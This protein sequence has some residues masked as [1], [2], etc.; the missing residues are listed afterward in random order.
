MNNKKRITRIVLGGA[1]FLIALF[2][3]SEFQLALYLISYIIVGGDVVLKAIKNIFRGQVFDENFLMC[4]ATV[5]AFLIGEYPEGVAVML[6]YQVGEVFQS[7]AVDQSRKSI[8]S[9]MDIRPDY[10]NVKRGSEL[11]KMDPDEVK[12]DD[13]IV[14]KAG[15]R[16]P[17]D[18]VVIDGNSMIDTSALTGE[19]VPRE[20]S[21]G[22]DVLSGCININGVLTVRVTKEY[23][24][25]TV[26]K[27]LDLV[28]NAS[29]KKSNSENFITKFARY[30]TPAVVIVAAMLAV[31]P[32]LLIEG[33][34]FNEWIYRALTFLVISCPCALVISVPLSFFGGI[35]AASKSGVL[36]KGSNYLEA[37]A[38][39]EMVVF[40]KTGTLT[41]GVFTVQEINAKGISKDELLELTAYAENY[42][43]HPISISLKQAYNKKIDESEITDV[44]EISG[45]GV[46]AVVK[47]KTVYAGNI[48]LMQR[49]DAPYYKGE[50]V[51]TVV[52]VAIDNKYA[53]Y[54][55][56]ADEVKPDAA[57]AIHELKAANI[58]QTVML[59]GDSNSVG[60]KVAKE[61]GL[62]KAYTELLPAG[63]VEK[64][65]ELLR[66][67]SAKGK[68]AFVG[69]GINDA[70]VLARADI[71]IAMGGLGSD[72]AIEAADIVIMTDE[73]SKI[74]TAMKISKR[75]LGIAKQ[76]IVFALGVK[77]IVLIMGAA[78]IA[79]MWEAVFADV[80][81]SVIAILNAMRV[82][83]I[84]KL[85]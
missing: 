34:T 9:L 56:I 59:T 24:E 18:G 60:M 51:G 52:H 40:D 57:K 84:K 3:K 75:T 47:G 62:D 49:I 7:Y 10:A 32:P 54:I 42:S 31:L 67:K 25:S 80:G 4:I 37:L 63:K 28:E 76:N 15:E 5:G 43:N 2:A 41:K 70:P 35:G 82:L 81:V 12:I 58:K 74:A 79:T 44:E 13:I 20:L 14:I 33:A 66:Q 50:I 19:S 21:V 61:L 68:L 69:D 8:V 71:G 30:Y 65:E 53:G 77:A 26:S 22:S 29:S 55:V 6:F 11:V 1:L 27:I 39:T 83:N 64:V 46:R 16:I 48:K 23:E 38:E 73:P 85:K 45:H 78:G 17:L 72:A 36:V